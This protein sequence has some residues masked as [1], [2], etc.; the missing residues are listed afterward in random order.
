MNADTWTKSTRSLT[1][2]SCVEVQWKTSSFSNN[3][4]QCVEVGVWKKSTASGPWTTDNCVEVA[5][6]ENLEEI[7]VRDT[8]LGEDSPVLHFNRE[9]WN[10]FR[11]G[12]LAGEFDLP[13]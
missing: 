11:T 1:E 5:G 6:G 12:M 10:A 4:G 9:E 13:D 3:G 7:L 8:K 2:S